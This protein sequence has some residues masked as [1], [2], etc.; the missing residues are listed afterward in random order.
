MAKNPHRNRRKRNALLHEK[1]EHSL[2]AKNPPG[3][4]DPDRTTGCAF[5]G[6]PLGILVGGLGGMIAGGAIAMNWVGAGTYAAAILPGLIGA[7]IGGVIGAA[8]WARWRYLHRS[9]HWVHPGFAPAL[10]QRG[11][12]QGLAEARAFTELDEGNWDQAVVSLT[13]VIR[14][15]PTLIKAYQGRAIGYLALKQA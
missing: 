13:E 3:R 12:A 7:L 1:P 6:A 14:L 4:G 2:M 8:R 5:L 9:L 10:G 11:R 15:N